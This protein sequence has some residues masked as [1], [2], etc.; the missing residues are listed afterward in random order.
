ME[1]FKLNNGNELP[2]VCFGPGIPT[3][4]FK[5]HSGLKKIFDKFALK[6]NERTYYNGIISALQNGAAFIDYAATYGREDI[7]GKALNELNIDRGKIFLTTRVSNQSQFKGTVRETAL[8][9]IERF[10]TE[11][12]DLLMFHW[13]VP[14]KFISTWE[15]LIKLQQ[16]GYC[17]NIGVANCHQ[18]HLE[19]L[20]AETS[21]KPQINQVEIHPL[22][23]QKDLIRYCQSQNIQIEAYTSLARMDERIVR[24]PLMK[25]LVKKY[26]KNLAQLILRWHIQNGVLPIFR[27]FNAQRQKENFDIFDFEI[28]ADDMLKIDSV[29]I[30]SRLRYDPDNCDFTIL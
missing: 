2:K 24:L 19:Q 20:I 23:S 7:V 17:R 25:D 13:P 15:D 4:G 5:Y 11:Y 26:Q 30:N 8:R 10:G 6:K 29:N 14:E 22:F 28:S 16:E 27:S 21:V 3:R 12:V 9:S 18:H 1:F